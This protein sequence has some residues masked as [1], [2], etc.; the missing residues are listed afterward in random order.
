MK[1]LTARQMAE[2]DR[3]TTDRY[4]IPSLLLMEN[5]GRSVADEVENA[6]PD[7][8]HKRVLIFCGTGNNG[9]DGLVVARHLA[10]EAVAG[11]PDL[12]DPA[13]FRGDAFENWKI[14]Q[15]L[16]LKV[17][18]LDGPGQRE[19]FLKRASHADVI[20]DALF[21]TGFPNR[22]ERIIAALSIGSMMR[23]PVL[24]SYQ[25]IFLPACSQIR[26]QLRAWRYKPTSR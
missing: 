3:L 10:C 4:N 1:I 9:G 20:V 19:S 21:G 23:A 25:S 22:S 7:A 8:I 2:V 14:L 18:V 16:S 11:S 17:Q 12:G 24:S 5:A 6:C 26:R 13:R 15:N